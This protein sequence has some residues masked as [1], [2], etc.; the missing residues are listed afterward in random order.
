MELVRG[1]LRPRRRITVVVATMPKKNDPPA[2]PKSEGDGGAKE[3]EVSLKV[4]TDSGDLVAK[5][6]SMRRLSIKRLFQDKDVKEFFT[7]L[8]LEEMRKE[9]ARLQ[10]KK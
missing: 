3:R 8:L 9:T 5:V 2:P 7:H 4:D 1:Y 10:G 6:A